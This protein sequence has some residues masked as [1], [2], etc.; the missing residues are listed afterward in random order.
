M[1]Y[2]VLNNSSTF[3]KTNT[4]LKTK[5]LSQYGGFENSNLIIYN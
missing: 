2:M 1:N 5:I 4:K 3:L